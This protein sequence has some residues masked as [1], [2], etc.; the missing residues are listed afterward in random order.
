MFLNYIKIAI[1]NLRK[2]KLFATINI[3]GLALGLTIFLF[4]TL[5]VRYE[6]THDVFYANSERIYTVGSYELHDVRRGPDYRSR[7]G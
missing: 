4:G 7:A 2:H 1:R 6:T 3:L 5:L